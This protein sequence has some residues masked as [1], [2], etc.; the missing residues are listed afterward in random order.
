VNL[1]DFFR[2]T[3]R[4]PEREQVRARFEQE[5]AAAVISETALRGDDPLCQAALSLFVTI[6][7][8]EAGNLALKGLATGGVYVAG[9]IAPKIRTKMLDGTFLEAF[10]DKGRMSNLVRRM[11]VLLVLQERTAL[12]GA[13]HCAAR[14]ARRS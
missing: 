2:E 14:L 9:G 12:Q 13:A 8:A 1:Y 4:H 5:D 6:Y 11:P 3:G 10:L 7:G